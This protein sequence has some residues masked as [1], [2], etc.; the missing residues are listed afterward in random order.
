MKGLVDRTI[1]TVADESQKLR[2]KFEAE[3]KE[4]SPKLQATVTQVYEAAVKTANDFKV[5]AE[6]AINSIAKKN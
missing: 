3:G 1:R 5:Q 2:A 4:L 6:S